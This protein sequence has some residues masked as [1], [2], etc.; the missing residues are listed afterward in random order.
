MDRSKYE[1]EELATAIR[2]LSAH[3][4]E[5]ANSGHPGLPL[6]MA[7][8][9]S[10]L[11]SKFINFNPG[12]P[13][14]FWR[15]RFILSAGH[16]SAL[17]YSILFLTGYKQWDIEALKNFRQL[18]SHTAGHPEYD[19]ELGIETTT[20]PLGQ[21]LG[22]AVGMAVAAKLFALSLERDDLCSKIYVIVSDG[23]M[24]EGIGQEA[25]SLAGNLGLDN[26]IVL[27]DDNG[28]SID[29]STKGISDD[30]HIERV[31]ASGWSAVSINGHDYGEICSALKDAQNA[32]RPTF[33]ACRTQIAKGALNKAGKAAA[34]GAPLGHEEIEGMRRNLNW[35]HGPFVIPDT[36]LSK[37]R[38]LYNRCLDKYEKS[39]D[40]KPSGYEKFDDTFIKNIKNI[41]LDNKP[42]ATRKALKEMLETLYSSL[43]IHQSR[44]F[45]GGSADLSDSNCTKTSS[46]A[47]INQIA[48]QGKTNFL[49]NY[50]HYGVREHAMVSVMNGMLLSGIKKVYG[51]TF[52]IF[53]DYC[54]PAI[55]L[56][57]MMELPIV[58]VCT[59][60]SIGLGEDGPTHQPIEQ[61]ANL[62]SIPNLN[63]YRP[64]DIKE[65]EECFKLAFTSADT[66]SILSL[67]RQTVPPIRQDNDN[68]E[69]KSASGAYIIYR[70]QVKDEYDV[71][72]YATGSEVHIAIEA[73]KK[74]SQ[75]SDRTCV[76]VSAPC[77]ELFRK[78][79]KTYREKILNLARTKIVVEASIAQG[80]DEFLEFAKSGD[81]INFIG[82]SGYGVSAPCPLLYKHF[83]ITKEAITELAHRLMK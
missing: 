57:A 9:A 20:G 54:K 15:D 60:D 73:A 65:V 75:D 71:A 68:K 79:A 63:V 47:P 23:C 37:S 13:K 45:I 14:W 74:I 6:G 11:F 4:V 17:L 32:K 64:C 77:L 67:T 38:S 28:I 7:D 29:G 2:M 39:R 83:G 56:A 35:Q 69:N 19:P 27:F 49:G 82:M 76:V 59:H 48:G 31:K 33:I 55:R 34:H 12:D 5:K 44:F 25:I 72:I 50:L 41:T 61:L 81:I 58:L 26:L 51:G 3:M 53:T 52:L 18:H 42:Q 46:H 10:V 16:G 24:M 30:N 22:N 80:W 62:R 36:I 66:P 40:I 78:Q 1:Y 21:G 70:S 8:V 43:G